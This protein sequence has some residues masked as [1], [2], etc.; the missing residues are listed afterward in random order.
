MSHSS[1]LIDS[2]DAVEHLVAR[3]IEDGRAAIDTELVWE[4]TYYPRLALVQV[5]FSEEEWYLV[6]ASIP[7]LLAPFGPLLEDSSVVKILHDAAQDLAVLRR[8]TG[9]SPRSVYDT[10]VAAGFA[11]LSSTVS[12][13]ALLREVL[14]VELPKTETR[15]D[16]FQRPLTQSQSDYAADDV[17]FL[18][19]AQRL[20]TSR[21]R[22]RGV[23]QWLSEELATLDDPELY[24]ERDERLQY[25]RVKG[26]GRLTPR[27]LAV[28]RELAAW[29]EN[30]ARLQDRP[31]GRISSDKMLLRLATRPPRTEEDMETLKSFRGARHQ[32]QRSDILQAIE[33]GLAVGKEDCPRPPPRSRFDRT[34]A[35][36]ADSAIGLL[37]ERSAQQRIDHALVATRSE[38]RALLRDGNDA[39]SERHR[40]LNGWRWGFLGRDLL[41][42]AR[43][44]A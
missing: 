13:G 36:R 19:A 41:N 33:A 25:E 4:R 9:H 3:A 15:T 28:L 23:E 27:Q 17:R 21:A 44:S 8:A 43:D 42:L 2:P 22:D 29:R 24:A 30:E 39:K 16:W 10:R 6:D 37:E 18:V 38:V 11:G 7:H 32:R 26:R 40:L 1:T 34:F 12:L 5:A 35:Q 31:R 14:E 20:L